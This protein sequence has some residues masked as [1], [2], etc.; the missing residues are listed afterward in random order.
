MLHT[1][2]AYT[3]PESHAGAELKAR[4]CHAAAPG[5]REGLI[6]V[7]HIQHRER[8]FNMYYSIEIVGLI[9]ILT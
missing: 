5:F 3:Y 7:S 9:H 6:G 8:G 4:W 2:T 1:N